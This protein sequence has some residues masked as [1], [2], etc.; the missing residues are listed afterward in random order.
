MFRLNRN[1]QKT[2]RNSLIETIFCIFMKIWSCVCL[3]RFVSKQFWLFQN[4]SDCFDCFG[5]K[6]Q[7]KPKFFD[8]GLTKQTETKTETDLVSVCFGS[9]T[10]IRAIAGRS[11]AFGANYP[12][13][14]Y[15][16]QMKRSWAQ[17]SLSLSSPVWS[18]LLYI[19]MY[20]LLCAL[21][22]LEGLSSDFSVQYLSRLA[23]EVYMSHTCTFYSYKYI[24]IADVRK[25]KKLRKG[26]RRAAG[27]Q[28]ARKCHRWINTFG[29]TRFKGSMPN[30]QRS[31]NNFIID[32][33]CHRSPVIIDRGYRYRS[34]G[35]NTTDRLPIPSITCHHQ[36]M[37]LVSIHRS[38]QNTVGLLIIYK[39][40]LI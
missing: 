39:S 40:L 38:K 1:K 35:Q 10:L 18:S 26:T 7:S 11:T 34:T 32:Y 3:F 37:L 4:S 29:P 30:G 17:S 20:L 19:N 23:W 21:V 16:H 12:G 14:I 15:P 13:D 6:H 31:N 5:S 9:N 25:I 22:S 28:S 8:F 36:S 2:N 27:E 24:Y 33:Q